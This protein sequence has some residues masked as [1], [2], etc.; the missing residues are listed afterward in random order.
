MKG[1]DVIY[2]LRPN[3]AN[4]FTILKCPDGIYRLFGN[5][6][7]RHFR[8]FFIE[9]KD[10]ITF[11]EPVVN[12]SAKNIFIK[13]G[14]SHN[15]YPFVSDGK[16]Y[17][18]GGIDSWKHERKWREVDN[19]ATF[20]KMFSER[21]KREYS[22]DEERFENF[23]K[24]IRQ[25]DWYE[26][27]SGLYLFH[28]NDCR[29]FQLVQSEP[30]ITAMHDGFISALEWGKS[31]EFDSH[32]SI[33]KKDDLYYLFM[34]SNPKRWTRYV[35]YSTSKNL[36]SWS[37]FNTIHINGYD[38][39]WDSY[40]TPLVF[41]HPYNRG[42]YLMFSPYWRAEILRRKTPEGEKPYFG[43][44]DY[45]SIRILRSVDLVNWKVTN[46]IFKGDFHYLA[47]Q[48][49]NPCHIVN[50]LIRRGD[51][52]EFFIHHN[53][54]GLIPG[55]VYIQRYKQTRKEFEAMVKC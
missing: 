19:F 50:G 29:N 17:G 22:K 13:S 24:V 30:I 37:K 38:D 10:G 32:F 43:K 7:I 33:V 20:K 16:L 40:Y 54:L 51:D 8:S 11:G 52:I 31:S 26:H 12:K 45:T 46:D 1:L 3:K 2:K 18:I 36:I 53:Y 6:W 27:T 21:F 41:N 5:E 35:Q 39:V 47:D 49:K 9:S 34:R 48:P 28:A 42:V 25:K 55:D 4:Y 23:K 14:A 44:M 15:F